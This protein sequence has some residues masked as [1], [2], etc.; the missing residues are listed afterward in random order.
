[1]QHWKYLNFEMDIGSVECV[2]LCIAVTLKKQMRTDQNK[3]LELS[4]AAC[5]VKDSIT[6]VNSLMMRVLSC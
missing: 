5:S 4:I 3:D 1:M 6:C 2:G